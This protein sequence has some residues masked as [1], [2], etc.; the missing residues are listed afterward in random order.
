[1][2]HKIPLDRVHDN[3]FQPR[4]D[5]G[6]VA[7]LA[8]KIMALRW[9]RP[10]TLGLIHPP[11]GRVVKL[12]SD[13][14][15][16]SRISPEHYDPDDETH[17]VQLAEGHRRLRAFQ[18]LAKNT[19]AYG[20]IPV[21]LAE[22]TDEAMDAI[23]WDENQNRKDLTPV[24]EARALQRS[25]ETFGLSHQELA[26]QRGI[27]R[28][29][30]ANKLRLLRLPDDVLAAIHAGTISERHG[31]AFLPALEIDWKDV[32]EEARLENKTEYLVYMT[33]T[34]NALKRRMLT[35][36]LTA[37][38]VRD[39]VKKIADAVS[40]ARKRIAAREQGTPAPAPTPTTPNAP[41]STSAQAP[42]EA[43]APTIAP[44]VEIGAAPVGREAILTVCF[45]VEDGV[46]SD[47][48]SVSAGT[49][50]KPPKMWSNVPLADLHRIIDIS[51]EA[52][53]NGEII[54]VAETEE[55]TG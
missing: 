45:R 22:Y 27:D 43:P 25:M 37:D 36:D 40:Y 7:E 28:S 31:I 17:V 10:D 3:P 16:T 44:P 32:R 21:D 23:A 8:A 11:T 52:V 18:H 54:A 41:M 35:G 42:K 30:V 48:L 5:Y 34:P 39:A 46:I 1:M 15:L 19:P 14:T 51:I 33:P 47:M 12:A 50:G 38:N 55:V 13:G 20:V 26:Q 4:I 9:A 29:T 6:D 24:E 2:M 49:M 53:L